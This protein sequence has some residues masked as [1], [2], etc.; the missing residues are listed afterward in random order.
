MKI[1]RAGAAFGAAILLL[2]TNACG[3]TGEGSGVP[4]A[5]SALQ[6]SSAQRL[7]ASTVPLSGQYTGTFTASTFGTGA[8]KASFAAYQSGVGGVL[9][10][11]PTGSPATKSSVVFVVSGSSLKGTAVSPSGGSYC[12]F[13]IDASYDSKSRQLSGAYSP[14]YGCA[15]ETGSFLLKHLCYYRGSGNGSNDVRP[16]A[17]PHPC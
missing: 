17:G 7:K 9:S 14:A 1:S 3:A 15:G 10:I 13:L 6:G 4:S 11:T 12:T 8:A 5:S 2:A 16:E